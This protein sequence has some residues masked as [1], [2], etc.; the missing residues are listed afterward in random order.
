[1]TIKLTKKGK[2]FFKRSIKEIKKE[3]PK[4]MKELLKKINDVVNT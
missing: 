3:K 2:N 1:M 4:E